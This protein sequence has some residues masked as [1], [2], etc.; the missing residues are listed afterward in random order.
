MN[1][2]ARDTRVP[3]ATILCYHRISGASDSVDPKTFSDQMA[4]LAE[5]CEVV[6]LDEAV[7]RLR[8]PRPA[9]RPVVCLTF[10]DGWA[11]TLR[12]AVPVLKNLGLR[13]TLFLSTGLPERAEAFTEGRCGS[14]SQAGLDLV[15]RGRSRHFLTWE[16]VREAAS[17]G[18][19]RLEAH[20][21]EHLATFGSRRVEAVFDGEYRNPM[22]CWLAEPA[23]RERRPGAPLYGRAQRSARG[24][25][26]AGPAFWVTPC[27]GHASSP[28]ADSSVPRGV[29][30]ALASP[31]R[32]GVRGQRRISGC[33]LT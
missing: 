22:H 30:Q 25:K 21:H 24:R 17:T 29:S 8:N 19:I 2:A 1:T 11:D 5:S 33:A 3:P 20:G 13:A 31:C 12:V 28:P 14:M 15:R 9:V 16:E 10:D 23:V 32:S 6:D 18:V 7:D 27:A 26:L 4:L